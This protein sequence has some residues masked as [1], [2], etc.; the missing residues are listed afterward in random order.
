VVETANSPCFVYAVG[1][2]V[3][4]PLRW[5]KSWSPADALVRALSKPSDKFGA[6]DDVLTS[7]VVYTSHK[8]LARFP[9]RDAT[10]M[11]GG[12]ANAGDAESVAL[13]S[14]QQIYAN[15]C[16]LVASDDNVLAPDIAHAQR[17]AAARLSYKGPF[18]PDMFPFLRDPQRKELLDYAALS[19]P[20]AMA[21][22]ARNG[23]PLI[24]SATGTSSVD[25]QARALAQCNG[26]N[27]GP[28]P[29]FLYAV[30]G[31]VILPQRRTEPMR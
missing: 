3:V 12:F 1:N 13:E 2:R 16:I 14:C 23:N 26:P 24:A 21:V 9:E 10:F 30:N 29:C 22:R 4:L 17:R 18:R 15:P 31:Q 25:A 6:A 27:M 28:Y 20:K 5:V 7:A 8:A 19:E 11:I